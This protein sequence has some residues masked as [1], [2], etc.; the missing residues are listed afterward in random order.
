[1]SIA[2]F[3]ALS[4]AL[5]VGLTALPA[6][7][8]VADRSAPIVIEAD[9]PGTLDLAN[10]VIVFNGNVQIEQGTMQ[11]RADRIE[12]REHPDGSRT[13]VA[14]GSAGRP[15]TY[16]QKREGLNE[17]VDGSADRI[18]YNSKTGTLRLVG[19]GSI[20]RLRGGVVADQISGAVI[21]WDDNAELFSVQGG[22]AP[23]EGGRVRAV[24][25]PRPA[26]A[27]EAGTKP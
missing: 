13:A 9:R 18:D 20:R 22:N 15:A 26:S 19:N 21:T 24:L 17:T 2:P 23:A 14:T 7:A 10:Q 4:L 6:M 5:L 1:M 16:R 12:V 27:P 25:T 8:D 3:S 11:I